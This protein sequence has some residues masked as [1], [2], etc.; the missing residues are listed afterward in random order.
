MPKPAMGINYKNKGNGFAIA[1]G[2]GQ[3]RLINIDESY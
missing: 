1:G 3:L 2:D